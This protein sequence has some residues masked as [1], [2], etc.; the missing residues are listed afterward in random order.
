VVAGEGRLVERCQRA[1]S[2][3][4]VR[5]ECEHVTAD[6]VKD[7][8]FFTCDAP[9]QRVVFL[10]KPLNVFRAQGC[11][12]SPTSSNPAFPSVACEV[13]W[14]VVVEEGFDVEDP[15]RPLGKRSDLASIVGGAPLRIVLEDELF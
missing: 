13:D 4:T 12:D 14:L 10:V 11:S 6:L 9:E 5:P 2:C 3:D 7:G 1:G 15:L 8:K